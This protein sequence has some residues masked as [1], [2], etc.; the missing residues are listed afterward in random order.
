[1]MMNMTTG[2]QESVAP[3]PS[4]I[5]CVIFDI[6]GTMT[7]TNDLIFASFNHV[8][9]KRLG[10]TFSQAE[11]INLFGPPEEGGLRMVFPEEQIGPAMEELCEFYK[12]HHAA[13]AAL[14]P[15]IDDGL[16]YLKEKGIKLAVFTGKGRRTAEI[17]LQEL[18]IDRYFDMVVSGNDVVNHKPHPE[19]IRKV[20]QAFS[21]RPANVLM[22]GDSLGD[23]KASRAAGVRMAAVLWDS[24]DR[25]RVLDAGSDYVFHEVPELLAWF[26]AHVN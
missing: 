20:L 1:M 2:M 3:D 22:I 4:R 13:L 11:I 6:D 9:A 8:A 18:N 14:H 21:L 17:T 12:Q 23:I 15:G 25:D 16:R 19:G 5:E 7:R 24:Y 10:R 26:R